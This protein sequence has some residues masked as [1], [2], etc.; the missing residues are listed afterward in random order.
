MVS[1]IPKRVNK[2]NKISKNIVKTAVSDEILKYPI[3]PALLKPKDYTKYKKSVAINKHSVYFPTAL[4]KFKRY[5]KMHKLLLKKNP[6]VYKTQDYIISD[7]EKKIK[8]IK[9]KQPA[10][11]NLF[12]KIENKLVNSNIIEELDQINKHPV[13]R[14]LKHQFFY[15]GFSYAKANKKFYIK[16]KQ[17][18]LP[19]HITVYPIKG[20]MDG[21][22]PAGK[23]VEAFL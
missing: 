11:K 13:K 14:L 19:N 1:N 3:N 18:D 7:S 12:L 6:A 15:K 10:I 17:L 20:N 4:S 2:K 21:G 8:K 23:S 9:T 16:F 5:K 22:Y